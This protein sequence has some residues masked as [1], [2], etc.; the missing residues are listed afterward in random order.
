MSRR[1]EGLFTNFILLGLG[2]FFC[3]SPLAAQL[4]GSSGDVGD[5]SGSAERIFAPV[6]EVQADLSSDGTSVTISW[7]LSANDF[8]RSVPVSSDFT[9]GG[10]FLI[11]NDVAGYNVWRSAS[12]DSEPT[13]VGTAGAGQ[14]SFVDDSLPLGAVYTY[15]VAAVSTFSGEESSAMEADSQIDFALPT[16]TLGVDLSSVGEGDGSLELT[17]TATLSKSWSLSTPIQLSL[18]GTAENADGRDY[19]GELGDQEIIIPAGDTEGRTTLAL[20]LNDDNVAEGDDPKTI[21]IEGASSVT[22]GA[23]EAA[24]DLEVSGAEIAL[25]D[26]DI[27]PTSI[28]LSVNP[29][30]VAEEAGGVSVTVSGLLGDG[31]TVLPTGTEV[32]VSL[33]G[34]DVEFGPDYEAAE[35][36]ITIPA[37]QAEGFGTL[38]LTLIDDILAEGEEVIEVAGASAGFIVES[39][40]IVLNDNDS[41]TT[42]TLSVDPSSLSE[43]DGQVSVT[44]TAV[45]G[46]GSTALLRDA[47]VLVSLSGTH[48]E[49]GPDYEASDL[50]ILIPGRQTESSAEVTLTLTDDNLAEG[51]E[52]IEVSGSAA[53]FIVESA[54]I[55]LVDNDLAPTTISLSVD[56]SNLAE[57]DEQTTVTV[58]AVLGDG[59][60]ALLSDTEVALSLSGTHERFASDFEASDL[61]MIT[62]PVGSTA[63]EGTV[64]ISVLDDIFAEGDDEAIEVS[65]SADGFTVE[66]ALIALIDNDVP[67]SITLSVDTSIIDEGAGETT[68]EVT[69]MLGD[70][71]AVLQGDTEVMLSIAESEDNA[72]AEASLIIAAGEALGS[73]T[74]TISPVDDNLVE[75]DEIILLEGSIVFESELPVDIN[76]VE[77]TL[78]D[79]D[80]M[81]TAITLSLDTA[82]FDEGAGE[83]AVE[84]TATLGDGSTALLT[85]TQVALSVAES[86]D[87]AAAE[88]TLTIPAGETQGSATLALAPVDD[89]LVEGNET[90]VLEGTAEGYEIASV[91]LTLTDND[92]APTSITLSVDVSSFDEGT[93]GDVTVSA[94][95]GDGSTALLTDTQVA[96]SVAESEDNAAA[97]ATLTIPAGETQGS[98]TLAL[99][100]VDDNLVE[101]NE[102][103]VLEGTAEGY[104]IASVEL[105]LTDNDV[106]PTSITLSVDVS[107]FDEGTGGDVTVSAVLG[108]G[109]TALLTD[110]QVA[111]SVAES[112]DNAAAE[113]TLTIP[114]GETQGSATLALAPV[115]DNLVE[116]NETIVLEGT[117]E[118]Y[119]ISAVDL[120]VTD[121]EVAPTT[122]SLSPA[123]TFLDE[124]AGESSIEVIATLGDGST[125]LLTD[126]QVALSVAE[127]EDNAAAEATLT[128]PAGE[129]QGSA[130]LAL[131]PV[132]DNLVEGNETIVLEGTAEGYEISAVE[133]TLADND[134][135][136]TTISLSVD[137]SSF[138]EGTG[139]DVTVS[140]VLGDGS[141]ALLTDTQVALSVAESEDNAAASATL[142]IAARET[143][144]S[145]TLSLSLVDDNLAEGDETIVLEGSADG[146]EIGS[147]ELTVTDNDIA[148]TTITL[149]VDVS[150][151]DEEDGETPL[152][153]KAVL[154]D[155]STALLTD[156]QVSLSLSGTAEEDTDYT[157]SLPTITIGA[158]TTENSGTLTLTPPDELIPEY[159]ETIVIEGS[160]DGFTVES[161]TITLTDNDDEP[162]VVN[163]IGDMTLYVGGNDGIEELSDNFRGLDMTYSATSSNPGV[164]TVSAAGS[165]ITVKAVIEG[166][167]TIEVVAM[168]SLGPDAPQTFVV[169]VVTETAEVAIVGD[170]LAALGRSTLS[171]VSSA[172]GTRFASRPGAVNA[173][174]AG[175]SL[176]AGNEPSPLATQSFG[177]EGYVR[178]PLG[179]ASPAGLSWKQILRNSSFAVPMGSSEADQEL[180]NWT[181]WGLGD[182][183]AF[184]GSPD[185]GSHDG[186]LT[187]VYLGA[188]KRV[189]A[190]GQAGVSVS[191]SMGEANYSFSG[192]GASGDG[193]LTTVLTSVYPYVRWAPSTGMDIW[194]LGGVG[195]G[196]AEN[197]RGVTSTT[198]E[199]DLSMS[200]GLL[201]ARQALGTMGGLDMAL[202]GDVGIV[203]LSTAKG[204]E[205]LDDQAVAGQRFRLGVEGAR[206][207]LL[208]S[209]ATVT[210]FGELG[211]RFDGGD[212]QT[213]GGLEVAGGLR[214]KCPRSRFQVEARGRILALNSTY[215][216]RGGSIMASLA[217]GRDGLGL[218]MS[219]APRW[220]AADRGVHALW[221]D[222]ALQTGRFG[223][224]P[225]DWSMDALVGY[226]MRFQPLHSVLTPFA[227]FGPVSAD[228]SLMRLGFRLAV[229]T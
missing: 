112:E 215:K 39:A 80:V 53:G 31:S 136:P 213:G 226:S 35:L 32:V 196:S 123:A 28:S 5:T 13:L 15:S 4:T 21:L 26:N 193:S 149:S 96:L 8:V 140:A 221:R 72:A 127:S 7:N 101:G 186:T 209:C 114:A 125:A 1:K 174:L 110:T 116:G 164:A 147:V 12:D 18:S 83:T 14:T 19:V 47:D 3:A 65:G 168:N 71:S 76:P 57:G 219:L 17:A 73:A 23:T 201:G 227:E 139:G 66:P 225:D 216:E 124:G 9:S 99:A 152:E 210:P 62:I 51:D 179:L 98:A 169:A 79:N 48:E 153:V 95:L 106:A 183:Q 74:I 206:T 217:P 211:G 198:E 144:G 203:N 56:P 100:P 205:V 107:S 155:G 194:A 129:T 82:S 27:A 207:I 42:I 165:E 40:I 67:E 141:T 128:I 178:Y 126:T 60:T 137:V 113:A 163:R 173:T 88:A 97:E 191:Y 49:L 69:A 195:M 33:S 121:N 223:L 158:G 151:F 119:E 75:E 34:T 175:H 87:N 25:T 176:L 212:G 134:V 16:V 46:D 122:I 181:L 199:S 55:A 91:E 218:S 222:D 190:S 92:V 41:P 78:R 185:Y 64:S 142:T 105:T 228:R 159:D 86:E 11:V 104:E 54:M 10:G 182:Y 81:P 89:N 108:D 45:L 192:D 180:P 145:A 44:V 58:T 154:G 187:T 37:E 188:D 117:A 52:T 156:T 197:E 109:S 214:Y 208:A 2:I 160:A 143:T 93:G 59:S 111:L 94:V 6:S 135:A 162:T 29:S 132:D 115:D 68:V 43:G 138:D 224:S 103:I 90:I 172:I 84:A 229:L 204:E 150:S 63:G 166:K 70:G 177:L 85:D 50:T 161:V 61:T 118:G 130:T 167:S 189:A 220:G 102:T 22:G 133:L 148:P 170:A 38:T 146:Y 157:A 200:L 36:T 131:A 20:T 30:S 202:R 77:L 184:E 120:S 171:S 24:E